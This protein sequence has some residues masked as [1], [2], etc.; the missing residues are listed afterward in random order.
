MRSRLPLFLIT[1]GIML[2][3]A[4]LYAAEAD[5]SIPVY[6]GSKVQFELNLTQRDFLPVIRQWISLVP[7]VMAGFVARSEPAEGAKQGGVEPEVDPNAAL[8]SQEVM[9]VIQTALGGLNQVSAVSY[10]PP[11][12]VC[13]EEVIELYAQ[14]LGLSKG[15]LTTLR[16]DQ[17]KV[18]V[19]LFVKP[20]LTAMFGVMVNPNQVAAFRTDGKIDLAAI[21][22]LA[23]K[24]APLIA[25]QMEISGFGAET[26][27]PQPEMAGWAVV[28]EDVGPQKIRVLAAIRDVTD[29]SPTEAREFV[30]SLPQT[31][32]SGLS[33]EEA[34]QIKSDF[35]ALGAKVEAKCEGIGQS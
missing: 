1:L 33:E 16:V 20:E 15:W 4:V 34:N 23:A 24:Y 7:G 17:D 28:L 22:S 18:S 21:G 32:K 10:K 29:M 26:E 9:D 8:A 2:S 11:K 12:D 35:E 19:R 25:S 3:T 27:T 31:L 30:Q 13:P 6:P 14:K 5:S